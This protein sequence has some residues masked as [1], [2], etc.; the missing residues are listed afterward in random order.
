MRVLT[1]VKYGIPQGSYLGPLL[2]L[3]NI[4]DL[5]SVLRR[6]TP[7]MFVDDTSMW[8]ASD[9][10]PELL[11]LLRDEITLSEKWM[12]D[13]KFT[14]NTLKT[15]F[16]LISFIPELR[17]IEKTCCIH[18]QDESIYRFPYTKSLVFYT[19]Q[20]LDWEDHINH[21]IKKASAEIAVLRA[22]YLPLDVLQTIYRCLVENH[23]RY[24]D[25]V[26]GSCGEVLLTKLRKIQNRTARIVTRSEFDEDAEPLIKESGWKTVRELVR[27]DTAITM[28]RSIHNIALTYLSNIF[29]PLKDVHQI[30]LSDTSSNLRL[31]RVA[32]NMSLRSFSYQGAAVWNRLEAWEKMDTSLQSFKRLP[33]PSQNQART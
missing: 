8:V 33:E 14:L 30:E 11:H 22:T 9:S 12:W 15:E 27:Y 16:I 3:I 31:P 21:V 7:S 17:E 10:V 25:V 13:N 28:Y 24:G 20:H 5:P 32:T 4:N 6:A 18:I 23:I 26:C 1:V 2:F 19:Y 29:Q